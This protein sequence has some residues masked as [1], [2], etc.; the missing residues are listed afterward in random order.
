[1]AFGGGMLAF[2]R[3]FADQAVT[4]GRRLPLSSFMPAFMR[5]H[6]LDAARVM[7]IVVGSGIL[8]GGGLMALTA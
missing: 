4:R 3:P 6:D 5:E 1:M 8:V 2:H 7:V